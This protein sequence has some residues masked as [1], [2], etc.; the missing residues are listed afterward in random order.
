M[1]ISSKK[2]LLINIIAYILFLLPIGILDMFKE[3]YSTL[4]LDTRGYLYLV[5]LGIITGLLMAYETYFINGKEMAI[6][7]FFSLFIGTIIPHH[8]PYNLQGN[9]HLLFSYIGFA[10]MMIITFMNLLKSNNQYLTNMYFLSLFEF[11]FM[12]MQYG[13]VTT[14]LEIVI[15]SMCLLFNFILYKKKCR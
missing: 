14:M 8:V 7:M 4:S 1:P 9:M 2:L 15:M 13:M 3:N 10:G 12:Y 5:F 11:G 6:A